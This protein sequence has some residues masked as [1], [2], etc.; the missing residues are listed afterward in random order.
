MKLALSIVLTILTGAGAAS[1]S[2][3]SSIEELVAAM[4]GRM[5]S[6]A[7]LGVR[8]IDCPPL[9]FEVSY[10][11]EL[12]SRFHDPRQWLINGPY[13]WIM[14][15]YP[16]GTCVHLHR[17]GSSGN[18][19][20]STQ[21]RALLSAAKLDLPDPAHAVEQ[22]AFNCQ[23]RRGGDYGG[24]IP[25]YEEGAVG[26][27]RYRIFYAGLAGDLARLDASQRRF[28]KEQKEQLGHLRSTGERPTEGAYELDIRFGTGSRTRD[29]ATLY[30]YTE[31]SGPPRADASWMLH[32]PSDRLITFDDL[33]VDPDAVRERI[34][35]KY[36]D[37]LPEYKANSIPQVPIEEMS[38]DIG[39]ITRVAMAYE[40][41]QKYF[42][43]AR[44]LLTPPPRLRDIGVGQSDGD[45][46]FFGGS[47]DVATP[48]FF[49]LPLWWATA[50]DLED[51]FKPEF[52]SVL[53][54]EPCPRMP[55]QRG[56]W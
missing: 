8:L 17:E 23:A 22:R 53:V 46:V 44:E 45:L 38:E 19:L 52:R 27:H 3:R 42:K 26:G 29:L 25:S 10:P 36:L 24:Y 16:T 50:K 11:A 34:V 32:L 15:R 33:F 48:A 31:D 14:V 2:E 37:Y 6:D 18:G 49:D 9:G 20:A 4:Q 40:R 7:E 12:I 43:T 28:V 21:A 35:R 39:P 1:A 47:F 13:Q 41:T 5:L 54:Q 51:A 55:E 56:R 30:A